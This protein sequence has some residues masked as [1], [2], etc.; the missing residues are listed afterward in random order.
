M[1]NAETSCCVFPAQLPESKETEPEVG[2]TDAAITSVQLH[3]GL[4]ALTVVTYD[5]N[6]A[7][8]NLQDFTPKK[9]VSGHHR[10]GLKISAF[11]RISAGF[12]IY[13]IQTRMS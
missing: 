4:D 11:S 5:H 1:W 3:A 13:Q 2:G 12:F 9:H 6:I 8:H 7:I 10:Q